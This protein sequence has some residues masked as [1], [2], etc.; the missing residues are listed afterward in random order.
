MSEIKTATALR[1]NFLDD[2]H[3]VD[4]ARKYYVR[5]PIWKTAPTTEKMRYWLRK[6]RVRETEYLE[7]TGYKVL[8]DFMRLN[9]DWPLRAW[10]GLLL[11]YVN[12]RDDAKGIL[13]AYER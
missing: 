11:E 2:G 4:L 9:P 13:R 7:A 8:E 1:S 5:L 12:E 10:V 6:F 3:W